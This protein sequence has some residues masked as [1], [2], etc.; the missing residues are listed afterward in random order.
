MAV[1]VTATG[2]PGQ[3]GAKT[4]ITVAHGAPTLYYYCT[5]HSGMGGQA[6]T[7]ET[8]GSSNFK[9]SIPAIVS[10]NQDSGFSIVSWTGDGN[11]GATVGHGLSKTPEVIWVKNRDTTDIWTT[12]HPDL[13]ADHVIYLH[14]ANGQ[15]S[16]SSS[17]GTHTNQVIGVDTDYA[18]NKLDSK[19]IAYCFHSVEGYSKFGSFAG[20]SNANGTFVHLG[21][22]P[23]YVILKQNA[24]GVDWSLFDSKRLGLN[25]DNNNLRAFAA[26]AAA[27]QTDND[28]D[29]V[30]NG[31]K[32][33]RNF[34][35]NQGTVLYFA[36]AEQ[37]F[38]FAN[39]R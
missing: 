29:F 20:N 24:N 33:R 22:R 6:N 11:S 9:G 7:I 23:A 30:A 5:Q 12:V 1:G 16:S 8:H 38:K 4:V 19:M 18:T 10:A 17:F 36:W 28:I 26:S 32:C 25:V 21:F 35:N 14:L 27:E 39:A 3:T 2:T 13:S 37:P 34:A 31:F 15:N